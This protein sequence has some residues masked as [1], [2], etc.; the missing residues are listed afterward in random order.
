MGCEDD[1]GAGAG[2]AYPAQ[3]LVELLPAGGQVQVDA[4][5]QVGHVDAEIEGGGGDD[6]P[7]LSGA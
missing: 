7:E 4:V 6:A 5:V 2:A 3:A 1:E